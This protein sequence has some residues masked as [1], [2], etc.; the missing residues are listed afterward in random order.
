MSTAIDWQ[1]LSQQWLVTL[2]HYLW[3]AA[4]V[5]ILLAIA[6]R[7]SARASASLRYTLA[8]LAMSALP[9]CAVATLA[10]VQASSDS[11][12][13][14][15][16]TQTGQGTAATAPLM[17][18]PQSEPIEAPIPP[19]PTVNLKYSVSNS[20][21]DVA[22]TER[23]GVHDPGVSS[24]AAWSRQLTRWAPYLLCL[25]CFG[26]LVMSSR[27]AAAMWSSRRL[28][29]TTQSIADTAIL[30]VLGEQS[31]RLGLRRVPLTA[32]CR[33][34]S[35]PVVIGI[36]KPTILLPPALLCGLDPQHLAAILSHEMA[37]IRRY[38]L[39]VNLLQRIIEATFFFHPVT[40]WISSRISVERENCCDDMAARG[41]ARFE[42]ADALLRMAELCVGKDSKRR[43]SLAGMSADGRDSTDLGYRIRR[44]I[45]DSGLP[46]MGISRRCV[47]VALALVAATSVSFVAWGQNRQS[48]DGVADSSEHAE[49]EAMLSLFTPAPVW[50]TRLTA[51]EVANAMR[52]IS[53]VVVAGNKVLATS[54]NF[55]IHSGVHRDRPFAPLENFKAVYRRKSLDRRFIIELGHYELG[56]NFGADIPSY[57]MRVLRADDGQQ[58]GVT[59]QPD[60][61]NWDE[62]E[63]DVEHGGHFAMLGSRNSVRIYRIETG[64]VETTLPVTIKR[65]DALA[66]SPDYDW[67]VVSDQND[68]HF[69]KW[70][71]QAPVQTIHAGRKIDC[72]TFTPDGQYLAE[73]PAACKDIQIR[74]MRT[75][76]VVDSLTDEVESPLTVSSMDITPDGRFLVA[77]NEV[78]VD[79]TKRWIPHRIHVWDLGTRKLVFQ[80]ATDQWVRSVA[81]SDDGRQIIG[82][83]LGAAQGPVLAAWKLPGEVLN[84]HIE[85][86]PNARDRLGDGIQWSM[87]GDM[88]GLLSGARLVLPVEGLKP[89]SPLQVEYRLA[90]VSA[91]TKTIR[92]FPNTGPQFSTLDEGNRIRLGVSLGFERVAKTVT[93]EPGDAYVDSERLVSFNT[94]GLQPGNYEVV[95]GSA[96]FYPDETDTGVT[97]NIPHRGSIP[98]TL[99]GDSHINL[100]EL[101]PNDIHWGQPVAGLQLGAKWAADQ[102]SFAVG[103]TVEA[104][105]FVANVSDQPIACSL[106]VPDR[107]YGWLLNVE[108]ASGSNI[109]LERPLTRL[110]YRITQYI[111]LRLAPGEIA[112][113]TGEGLKGSESRVV[114]GQNTYETSLPRAR[115]LIV[116]DK[117]EA[118]GGWLDYSSPRPMLVS[119]GG[120]Y[121]VVFSAILHRPEIPHLRLG[122]NSANIPFSVLGPELPAKDLAARANGKPPGKPENASARMASPPADLPIHWGETVEGLRL[123]AMFADPP[124]DGPKQFKNHDTAQVKLFVQNLTKKDAKFEI[125]LAH[126]HDGWWMSIENQNGGGVR[127]NQMFV[128]FFVPQVTAIVTLHAG[129]VRSIRD[130]VQTRTKD[131][132]IVTSV[133]DAVFKVAPKPARSSQVCPPFIFGM[134]SGQYTALIGTSFRHLDS[135]D[136]RHFIQAAPLTFLVGDARAFPEDK[137]PVD[138]STAA[139]I[140][141]QVPTV[142]SEESKPSEDVD[143]VTMQLF[144]NYVISGG[145]IPTESLNAAIELVAARGGMNARFREILMAEFVKSCEDNNF[146]NARNN[147]LKVMQK[148]LASEGAWRWQDEQRQRTGE[149]NQSALAVPTDPQRLDAESEML[150]QL[151]AQGRQSDSSDIDALVIAI[152]QAHHPEAIPFLLDVLQN[153][154]STAP[155]IA[156]AEP[157]TLKSKWADFQGGSWRDARFHAAVGLAELGEATGVQWLLAKAKPN[158][159]GL[160]GTVYRGQHHLATRGSPARELPLCLSRSLRRSASR[161]NR[162]VGKVVGGKQKHLRTET[163]RP[164]NQVDRWE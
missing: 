105:L 119:R 37:H 57:A 43:D 8:C 94:T 80:I 109:M 106:E 128:W 137:T 144:H 40:W 39:L 116:G 47:F 10:F 78:S 127:P 38:D 69:W 85:P 20:L 91:E 59:I 158:N 82:E 52:R 61:V 17:D 96:F 49:E 44:I 104:D 56:N 60:A 142:E 36:L 141:P 160:D 26:V 14:V 139:T 88:D 15:R 83:F 157:V 48:A 77:H 19:E 113:I 97:H 29:A 30:R 134:P 18:L 101:P 66:F 151:I 108:D 79:A 21:D 164:Q 143:A 27:I 71:D 148:I 135:D 41:G 117:D 149:A 25:Y 58:V 136:D 89:G 122:L 153:P 32:I 75:L 159:F 125:T 123:G 72:L 34:V 138:E 33:Q 163:Y 155:P 129:E 110:G 98:F 70:R 99:Q 81:F 45:G 55:N 84:N 76:K 28:R 107:S 35:V 67:I 65:V 132:R 4:I 24:L 133:G 1:V 154:E 51:N 90:N 13:F 53:P 16:N 131:E 146:R 118:A 147:L 121:H 124:G 87:W 5:G 112:P 7:L 46:R 102:E 54:K 162:T 3:Q 6:L 86:P 161:G 152:R 145:K 22:G 12:V 126:P 64:A 42:Y 150:N 68:L 63:T 156:S 11:S 62:V 140:P 114:E 2:I 93:I 9:A 23:P 115:I 111:H 120:E 95:L 73:G 100:R 74:D 50:Q 92:A 130:I 103:T 31:E